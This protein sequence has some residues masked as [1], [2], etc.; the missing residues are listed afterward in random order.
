MSKHRWMPLAALG[1]LAA[2]LGLAFWGLSSA[3][4]EAEEPVGLPLSTMES[5]AADA[6][7]YRTA[8]GLNM[9]LVKREGVWQLEN[10]PKLTLS[11]SKVEALVEN[12]AGLR[13]VR[14]LEETAQQSEY[15]L[16]QPTMEFALS[17]GQ[18][19]FALTVGAQNTMTGA[20]YAQVDGGD[21][22]YT[23][24]TGDLTALCKTVEDLYGAV[25]MT[26]IAVEEITE[27]TVD[28][29]GE[30][31]RF[32]QQDGQWLL[33][34]DP[35]YTLDQDKVKRMA[36]T[37]CAMTSTWTITAPQALSAYGL[38]VPDAAAS[39]TAADGRRME[40][41]FGA[42]SEGEESCYVQLA[43]AEDVVY[44]TLASHREA[45]AYSKAALSAATPETAE[46]AGSE[47]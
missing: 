46:A 20:Y 27:M 32:R 30:T 44:E 7:R 24:E 34:D 38:D 13:A 31:L 3:P 12:L 10:D 36:N 19:T 18:T 14:R 28:T 2:L 45:F 42:L 29:G 25:E 9:A 47:D 41:R 40:V 8:D 4:E 26:D 6:V 16:A 39:L 22:V 1:V 5:A 17:S 23:V 15:G 37:L 11:Q 33:A 43:G 21:A 35:G